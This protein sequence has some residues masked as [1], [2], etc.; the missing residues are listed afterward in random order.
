L[1][2][3][4]CTITAPDYPLAPNYTYVDSFDMVVRLYKQMMQ[5]NGAG[6]LVI[7]GDSAG[8]GFAQAL[9][10]RLRDKHLPQPGQIILLLPG[11]I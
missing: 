11:W 3:T 7:M 4:G 1:K 6:N 10:Q 5:T 2:A 9:A 8:G